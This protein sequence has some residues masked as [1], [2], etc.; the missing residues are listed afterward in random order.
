[1]K[2]K[3]T[4]IVLILLVPIYLVL[5]F[6]DWNI[7][8]IQVFDHPIIPK[9]QEAFVETFYGFG[10]IMIGAIVYAVDMHLYNNTLFERYQKQIRLANEYKIILQNSENKEIEKRANLIQIPMDIKNEYLY[11][12]KQTES[13]KHLKELAHKDQKGNTEDFLSLE[14]EINSIFSNYTQIICTYFPKITEKKLNLC[15]LMKAEFQ[16]KE[17]ATLLCMHHS[18]V[19]HLKKRMFEELNSSDTNITNFN[20][21]IQS[22]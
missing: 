22:L 19:S 5:L 20:E 18:S 17:I 9:E 2:I 7:G 15:L 21:F 11:R 4:K 6:G 16:S 1:M 8:C 10:G 13:Y 14:T 3:I 12:L